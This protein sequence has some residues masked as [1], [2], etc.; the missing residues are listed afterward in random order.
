M[1]I[2]LAVR[3]DSIDAYFS[4]II[5]KACKNSRPLDDPDVFSV[6]SEVGAIGSSLID[7]VV[8]NPASKRK[9]ISFLGQDNWSSNAE[10]SV[11]LRIFPNYDGS[12]ST[13]YGLFSAQAGSNVDG[14]V[15]AEVRTDG[16]IY[17]SSGND[18]GSAVPFVGTTDDWSA[19]SSKAFDLVITC[20]GDDYTVYV[21]AATLG[22]LAA[23]L[24]MTTRDQYRV[25]HIQIGGSEIRR[26]ALFSLE[27]FVIWDEVIDPSSVTLSSGSGALNGASRTSW[28]SVENR[29]GGSYTDPGI[30]N[31]LSG[32]VYTFE[33]NTLTGIYAVPDYS[34]PGVANV[35]LGTEYIFNSNTLTGALDVPAVASGQAD[36]I[37]LNNIK[38]SLRFILNQQN[39]SSLDVD[40][41]AG[42][43]NRVRKVLKINPEKIPIQASFF[44]CVT[45]FVDGKSVDLETMA[46]S[47][48]IGQRRALIDVKIV[49]L[50]WNDTFAVDTE[51]PADEDLE[52]LMENIELILRSHP[53]ISQNATTS[54]PRGTDYFSFPVSEQ[55]HLRAGV[56]TLEVRVDY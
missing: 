7:L 49:G 5:G 39:D 8:P 19:T 41:S 1:A 55:T 20:D 12:P 44:P 45:V 30:A 27:E 17:I 23:N 24:G 35:R 21:D 56:L 4:T 53:T 50:V 37:D 10:F 43:V 32:T 26:G 54:K 25:N 15:E 46:K 51:D 29:D 40:L 2:K 48:V 14:Y 47:Q 28:V 33:G 18:D 13:N 6:T 3:G 36:T 34:D 52:N 22:V 31:V 42:M 11:L 38:E 16:T 9:N